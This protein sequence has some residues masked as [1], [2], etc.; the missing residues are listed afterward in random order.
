MAGLGLFDQKNANA[1]AIP[2]VTAFNFCV[3]DTEKT[4]S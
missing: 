2:I 3:L 1:V 4:G